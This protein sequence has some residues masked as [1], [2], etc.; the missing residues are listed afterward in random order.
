LIKENYLNHSGDKADKLI[1]EVYSL[2]NRHPFEF[3]FENSALL[4]IDMQNYFLIRDSHAFIPSAGCI[5]QP[6]NKLITEFKKRNRTIIFTKHINTE[7]DAGM[8]NKWWTDILKNDGY[9]SLTGN[10]DISGSETVLKTQYDAF[11]KTG[12]EN[13]LKE[14]GIKQVVV[15]GVTANLCCESTA[16]SAFVRGFEVFFP[17]DCTAAYNEQLH[18]STLHNLAYGFAHIVKSKDLLNPE[19]INKTGE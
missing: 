18:L 12:L 15:T 14:N 16:R 10:L 11:Y 8:M 9:A 1:D 2:V 5:L 7:E 4:V 17:V 13:I 6:I 3:R 19:K